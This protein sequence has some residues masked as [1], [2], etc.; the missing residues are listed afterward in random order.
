MKTNT[1]ICVH[2]SDYK[3]KQLALKIADTIYGFQTPHD[4]IPLSSVVTRRGKNTTNETIPYTSQIAANN[5]A[6]LQ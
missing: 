1:G 3:S 2:T 4:S 6:C 5:S